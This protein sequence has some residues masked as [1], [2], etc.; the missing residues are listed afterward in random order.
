MLQDFADGKPGSRRMPYKGC[1]CL[2]VYGRLDRFS[3]FLIFI[4]PF[5]DILE[6]ADAAQA[7]IENRI[8]RLISFTGYGAVIVLLISFLL[9][10]AFSRTVTRP[11]NE[12]AQGARRLSKGDFDTRVDIRSRDELGD[13]GKVFN[14]MGPRLKEHAQMSQSLALAREVQ[15]TLLPQGPPQFPGFDIAGRSFNC[16]ETGGDYFDY[17][18]GKGPEGMVSV[19]VGDVAGH[20]IA[21]A[22]LMTTA[23]A[24]IRQRAAMGGSLDAIVS[25]VNRHLTADI[26][27]SGRFMTLFYMRLDPG[28]MRTEW[29]RAGHDP[30]L[31]YNPEADVFDELMGKGVPLGVMD[32]AEYEVCRRS[33]KPGDIFVIGTDGIWE[34][35]N[36]DGEMF[37]KRSVREIIERCAHQPAGRIL[38][39]VVDAVERF[40]DGSSREDDITLV[41]IK[42]A[43]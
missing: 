1:D 20:G 15:Q 13:M 38:E 27:A 31:F 23:R 41:V 2:W 3:G 39:A 5:K 18:E 36:P 22:L 24:L 30:A 9:A 35:R 43:P 11:L 12:L 19:L 29:V 17:L 8:D 42:V 26:E 4:T 14:K 10:L 6:P 21:S 33:M 37:G 28:A 16:D 40:Q 25:D 34:A 32:T 7:T